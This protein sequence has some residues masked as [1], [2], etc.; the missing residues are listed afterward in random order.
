MG[1]NTSL[2]KV[3]EVSRIS[4]CLVGWR[5]YIGNLLEFSSVMYQQ[6]REAIASFGVDDAKM[7]CIINCGGGCPV[8]LTR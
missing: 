5:R 8:A 7:S 3:L 2:C 6:L 1:C 4:N